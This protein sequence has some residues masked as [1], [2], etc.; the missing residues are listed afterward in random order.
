MYMIL[1]FA[2]FEEFRKQDRSRALLLLG[3]LLRLLFLKRMA[4]YR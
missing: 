2:V 3:C 4:F 1:V